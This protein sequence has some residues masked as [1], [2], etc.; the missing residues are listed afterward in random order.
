MIKLEQM[1]GQCMATKKEVIIRRY[2]ILET[3][4]EY[5]NHLGYIDWHGTEVMLLKPTHGPRLEFI[6][7]KVAEQM[8]MLACE[9]EMNCPPEQPEEYLNPT[10][11]RTTYDEFNESDLL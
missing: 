7:Q 11:P 10:K 6:R 2:R 9:L 1:I 3:V 5:T 4:G 8:D